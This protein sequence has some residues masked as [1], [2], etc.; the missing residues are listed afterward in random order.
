[1]SR[2]QKKIASVAAA[3]VLFMVLAAVF[4]QKMTRN[5]AENEIN[6]SASQATD[7]QA[8]ADPSKPQT[9]KPGDA[10]KETAAPTAT[11][12]AAEPAQQAATYPVSGQEPVPAERMFPM[13]QRLRKS[14][15]PIPFPIPHC[16]S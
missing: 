5:N 10:S 6:P 2:K 12:Q 13:Q 11:T 14:L 15:S 7:P 9:T 8:A 3:L 4:V 16:R 1:M